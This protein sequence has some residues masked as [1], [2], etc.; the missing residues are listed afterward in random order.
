MITLTTQAQS[1]NSAKRMLAMFGISTVT[2]MDAMT[3]ADANRTEFV[4]VW[5]TPFSIRSQDGEYFL[6]VTTGSY[7]IADL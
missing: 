4:P 7:A 2:I 5:G 3:F 6:R 1:K